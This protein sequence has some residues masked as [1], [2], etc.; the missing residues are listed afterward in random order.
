M[1]LYF[2]DFPNILTTSRPTMVARPRTPKILADGQGSAS[3]FHPILIKMIASFA[4]KPI[5]EIEWI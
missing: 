2:I 5:I 3:G 1:K 4:S